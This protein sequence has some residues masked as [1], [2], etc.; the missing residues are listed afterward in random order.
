MKRRGTLLRHPVHGQLVY[1]P[2][3][4]VDAAFAVQ[5]PN[6]RFEFTV[7]SSEQIRYFPTTPDSPGEYVEIGRV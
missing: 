1:S 2:A 4:W 3:L 7:A 6:G 5:H